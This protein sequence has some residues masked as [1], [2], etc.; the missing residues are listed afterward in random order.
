MKVA[1]H[2]HAQTP[3]RFTA[4][5]CPGFQQMLAVSQ[6][7]AANKKPWKPVEFM[8]SSVLPPLR[9]A[10]LLIATQTG[11]PLPLNTAASIADRIDHLNAY[12]HIST[13]L[14][15]SLQAICNILIGSL[16]LNLANSNLSI[17]AQSIFTDVPRVCSSVYDMESEIC[18]GLPPLAHFPVHSVGYLK[19]RR[20]SASYSAFH[21]TCSHMHVSNNMI[22]PHNKIINNYT[23]LQEELETICIQF[24]NFLKER[25][26]TCL[27]KTFPPAKHWKAV[28]R[29]SKSYY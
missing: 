8:C 5:I 25:Y 13:P 9:N 14:R 19:E 6:K 23:S 7:P 29:K 15:I 24:H 26:K 2:I 21:N 4:S 16:E 10:T 1:V 12:H 22:V 20:I 27:C 11:Q 3:A 17:L 28:G 18:K